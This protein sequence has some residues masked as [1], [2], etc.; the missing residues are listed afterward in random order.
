MTHDYET[1]RS[2]RELVARPVVKTEWAAVEIHVGQVYKLRSDDSFFR[3]EAASTARNEVKL[4]ATVLDN[5]W[6]IGTSQEF[7]AQFA[8]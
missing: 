8:V 4:Q 7:I 5:V 2:I 6:W 1:S 3:L